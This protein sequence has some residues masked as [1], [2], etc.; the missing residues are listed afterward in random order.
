MDWQAIGISV[1]LALATTLILMIIGLPLAHCLAF[2]RWRGRFLFEAAV[3]LPLVLPPTVL[4][5]YVL[6]A[7]GPHSPIG[8]FYSRITGGMLPFSF[9]GLLVASVLYSLPFTV[10]PAAAAFAAVDRKLIEASWC[11]GIS[12]LAT[13]R[14]VIVPLAM[15]GIATGAILTFAHTLGEFGVVLMVGGNIPGLTRT[16]SISIYDQVQALNYGAAAQTSLFL[17]A[18]SFTVLACTY[19][20]QKRIWSVWPMS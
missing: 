10:Q 18:V 15:P 7:I 3:A 11:L 1:R 4:G 17:L 2:S 8:A 6:L 20:L 9:Q 16:V 13:F 12:R 5:F 14:R 19:A